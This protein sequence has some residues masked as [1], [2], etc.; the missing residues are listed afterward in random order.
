MTEEKDEI[1]PMNWIRDVRVGWG[2]LGIILGVLVAL[3]ALFT[4]TDL[5]YVL[6]P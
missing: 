5:W 2:T 1:S 3:W 6:F 4:F